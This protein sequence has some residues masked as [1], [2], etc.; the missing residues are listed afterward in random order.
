MSDTDSF[1]DLLLRVRNRD[2]AA[3]TELVR[4]FSP[5]IRRFIRIRLRDERL[6]RVVTESDICQSVM[7]SFFVRAALGQYDLESS[8]Q[9]MAL[10]TRM[11]RNKLA[12]QTTR[13]GAARRDYRRVEADSTG[14]HELMDTVPDPADEAAMQELLQRSMTLL[15]AD[16]LRVVELR[17]EGRN[18]PEIAAELGGS[19]EALRKQWERAVK[20][21]LQDLGLEEVNHE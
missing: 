16:E 8:E 1:R 10:L 5:T 21:T 13:E 6:R 11:A 18:W 15:S 2:G 20:R 7:A 12:N 19:A 9:L 14:A 4:R 17:R 3:A